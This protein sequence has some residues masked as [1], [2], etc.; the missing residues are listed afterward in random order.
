MKQ[1]EGREGKEGERWKERGREREM[2]LEEEK[3]EKRGVGGF[4]QS[5]DY[6]SLGN[7][8]HDPTVCRAR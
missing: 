2:G 5:F 4:L 7:I 3:E 6:W 1:W 8:S